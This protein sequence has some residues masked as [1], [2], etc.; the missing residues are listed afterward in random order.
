[1]FVSIT[2]FN[3]LLDLTNPLT[4]QTVLTDGQKFLF[5]AYQLNTL[6]LWKDD[7]GNPLRNVCWISKEQK[8]YEMQDG[9]ISEF[10]VDVLKQLIKCLVLKPV[11]RE[12]V[13]EPSLLQ[14]SSSVEHIVQKRTI[15]IEE[16][17]IKYDA[18]R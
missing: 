13:R 9:Q 17:E 5:L 4:T 8:L 14:I 2:G 6:H 1:M 18:T 3:S 16:E 10:N 7:N 15:I 12:S 11:D